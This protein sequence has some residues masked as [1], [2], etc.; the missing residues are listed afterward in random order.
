MLSTQVAV[1]L[2]LIVLV[3]IAVV[4]AAL[5]LHTRNTLRDQYGQRAL[6][7]GR[8]VAE[9][10][11]TV[12]ALEAGIPGGRLQELVERI[13]VET[14]LTYIAV[15]DEHGIRFTHPTVAN[16]GKP[17]S[18]DPSDALA[19]ETTITVETGTLGETMRAKLPVY[20][21]DDE[22]LGLVSAGISTQRIGAEVRR[23]L[24]TVAAVGFAGLGVGTAGAWLLAR[25]LRRKTL[26]LGAGDIA[27]LYENREATLLSIREGVVTLDNEGRIT[28]I[29]DEA[30]RLL[31]LDLGPGT[32]DELV[33][34]SLGELVPSPHFARVLDGRPDGGDAT[35]VTGGRMLVVSHR[36]VSA[37]GERIGAVVT[38][39]DRTELENLLGE[40]ASVKGMADSLRAKAHEYANRMHTVAGLLELG[41]VDEAVGYI[42]DESRF[43]QSLT[44]S[45]ATERGDPTLVALLLSKSAAASE[46]GIE[47]EVTRDEVLRTARLAHSNDTLVAVGNLIDNAF[48]AACSGVGPPTVHVEL[49]AEGADLIATV[50]DSGQGV[51][52]ADRARIFD[53]GYS[54]KSSSGRGVGLAL[55]AE[56][57]ERHRG[58]VEL[59]GPVAGL[60]GASFRLVLRD[61][62]VPASDAVEVEVDAV[63]R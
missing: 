48:D 14:G 60:T 16:I 27:T 63:T 6:A 18:T 19:G 1:T 46:R 33:G 40:L 44:E 17:L 20:G 3:T 54:T 62:I 12:E 43:A 59:T 38:L 25:R 24:G 28:L 57:A 11:A 10:P 4:D 58:T 22:L 36:Q 26:G 8:T 39:R 15:A 55:A 49:A 52:E 9:L 29:N 45:F 21:D 35:V 5:Y 37:R 61:M 13:R 7:V 53:L 56:A 42:T 47:L 41:H 51:P 32:S 23:T 34:R 30:R 2:V 31:G 50:S